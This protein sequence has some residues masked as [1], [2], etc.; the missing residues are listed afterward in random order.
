MKNRTKQIVSF[1]V[2]TIF[3]IALGISAAIGP[4]L[5]QQNSNEQSKGAEIKSRA[6][7]RVENEQ[8][9]IA[10]V[11]EI[12]GVPE[13]L[14]SGMSGNLVTLA[15][16]NTPFL[17]EQ[18]IGR[19][20]W[21]VVIQKWRL[22]LDSA[23]PGFEDRYER[24]FDVLV[25]PINGNILKIASRWPEGI[26]QM[27]P[28]PPAW[29]AQE[30]MGRSGLEKYHSFPQ[31]R[32]AITFLKALD[33][34]LSE[35]VG[36]P[37][38]AKQILGQYVVQSK[39][40]GEPRPVWAITLRGIR[41]LRSP[42]PPP[43]GA[44]RSERLY[45]LNR[46]RNIVH[47]QTGQWLSAGIS[48]Q[49]ILG[50]SSTRPNQPPPPPSPPPSV[51]FDLSSPSD[52]QEVVPGSIIQWTITATASTDD[53]FG[54]ALV[55]VDLV[56]DPFN[57]ELFDIPPGIPPAGMEDFDRPNGISNPDLGGS[58]SAYGGTQ[59]GTPG[60]MDLA[61]IGGAQNT[62]GVVG[63]GIG[64]DTQVDSGVGQSPE[65]QIVATGSFGAPCGPGLYIF[66]I[67][68]AIANVL[69][70]VNPAPEFSLVRSGT[71][72]I[73]GGSFSFNVSGLPP[74]PADLNGDG[75]VG[76]KDLL[77]LLGAWGPNPGHPADFDDDDSV[78]V[79][80]LLVLLGTWGPCPCAPHAEVLSLAEKLAEACVTPEN[81]DAFEAKMKDANASQ[82][83]KDNYYCWMD[84]HLFDCTCLTC[85]GALCPGPDPYIP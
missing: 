23:I 1:T 68:A 44:A 4:R 24:T 3:F 35:G 64:L 11:I 17:S 26:P 39:M 82:E 8:Q 84:H 14:R 73:S 56:Q 71:V 60:A 5:Y 70:E 10:Q 21:Q 20:L 74:C 65:G 66:S 47:A 63:D 81:W 51:T 38:V 53:N 78:G 46:M 62:F 80:D 83:D 13:D 45:V 40:Q 16:D 25:D 55:A 2:V 49:P 59:I 37:L 58:G 33:I 19:P 69:E 61:Q 28:E 41:I 76:V 29:S 57:P 30:Q 72:I 31:E 42:P 12:A 6:T 77:I 50:A 32:A 48:P 54:L 52:G 36:S 79:K 67:E 43:P 15:E 27:A 18:I 9:A 22:H 85:W 34:V 7:W 75:A